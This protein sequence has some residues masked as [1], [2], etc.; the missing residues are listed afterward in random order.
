MA[1]FDEVIS[2]KELCETPDTFTG[3]YL[4]DVGVTRAFIES[5]ITSD[6]DG[7]QEFLELKIDQAARMIQ[8]DASAH[9]AGR[10]NTTSLITS[11]RLG[12]TAKNMP[13]SAGGDWKGVEIALNNYTNYAAMELSSLSLQVNTNG[14]VPVRVYDLYQNKL[15]DTFTITAVSGQV[16]T[17]YPHVEYFSEGRPL[18]LFIG[19]DATGIT[20]VKTTLL[21]DQC[22]GNSTCTNEYLVAKGVT[23]STGHFIAEDMTGIDHTGGISFTYS[24]RCDMGAW[25]CSFA[26]ALKLPMAYKVASEMYLHGILDALNQRSSNTTNLNV[27]HMKETQGFYEAKYKETLNSVLHNIRIPTDSACFTCNAPV[28]SAVIMP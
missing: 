1:C 24:L 4:N 7:I 11:H 16:V 14:S 6:Y 22:C 9:F 17:I 19:Y 3:M 28:R 8:S 10:I 2:L 20:S 27:E 15:L 26:Q 18:H 13:T 21:R 5:V 23:N 12:W 25:L